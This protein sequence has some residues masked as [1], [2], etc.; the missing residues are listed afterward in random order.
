MPL[1]LKTKQVAGVTLIVGLAVVAIGGWYLSSLARVLLQESRA[2]AE[3]LTKLIYER[4]REDVALGVDPNDPYARLKSDPGL[5]S[6][7][8]SSIYSKGVS[9]AAIVDVDNRIIG[10]FDDTMVGQTWTPKGDLDELLVVARRDRQVRLEVI[11]DARTLA[12]HARHALQ[13]RPRGGIV[14]EL[15]E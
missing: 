5:D 4:A 14:V 11:R 13:L 15:R 7:L 10:H 2:R 1:S 9:Y 3:L 8:K 6:I 12:R